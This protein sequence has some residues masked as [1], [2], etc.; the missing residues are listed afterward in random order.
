MNTPLSFT[1]PQT[2]APASSSLRAYLRAALF[3]SWL[4]LLFLPVFISYLTRAQQLRL[5]IIRLFYKGSCAI[6]GIY[7][8]AQGKLTQAR[9]LLL[10]SN[11]SSYL[12]IFVLGSLFPVSFTP[13][14]EV[15]QWPVIGFLCVLADCVFV[16]RKP[17]HM[18]QA[19]KEMQNRL[20]RGQ[21]LCIFPEGTTNNGREIKNFKSGFFSLAEQ[22][23]L[24]VQPITLTYTSL[25]NAPIAPDHSDAVAWVGD[26]T[27]FGH[28]WRVLGFKNMHVH[29]TAHPVFLPGEY[30]D[31]KAL[32]AACEVVIKRQLQQNLK[33]T[34]ISHAG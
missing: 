4:G 14:R 3:I 16:E 24:P 17:S 15:R 7:I 31:R 12:D 5:A 19:R 2:P 6:L 20:M 25:N 34:E 33:Q 9:P 11:H 21:V 8:T 28:F 13:K 22:N 32:S 1:S 30:E 26:A 10:V 18:Q 27:F 29:V 23:T